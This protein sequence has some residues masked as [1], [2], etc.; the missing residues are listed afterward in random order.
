M[1]EQ[2]A[3]S[4]RYRTRAPLLLPPMGATFQVA[5]CHMDG[6]IAQERTAFRKHREGMRMLTDR[7]MG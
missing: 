1:Q 5:M 4:V 2:P 6:S 7:S 3:V